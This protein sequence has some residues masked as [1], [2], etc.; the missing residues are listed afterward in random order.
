MPR[1]RGTEANV[2]VKIRVDQRAVFQLGDRFEQLA[3]MFPAFRR[4]TM[5]KIGTFARAGLVSTYTLDL[6]LNPALGYGSPSLYRGA[7]GRSVR[8][9]ITPQG[10]ITIRAEVEGTS[11]DEGIDPHQLSDVEREQ[12]REWAETKMGVT[13]IREVN[14]IIRKIE[15]FGVNS[16]RIFRDA[17]GHETP[18]GQALDRFIE[19]T[20][21]NDLNQWLDQA[22]FTR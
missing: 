10:T 8:M 5:T 11:M 16:R 22:G 1:T 4:A 13:N 15:R 2:P 12:I 14:A 9:F 7:F 20:I 17:F 19:N 18:R 3:F 21:D 6:P